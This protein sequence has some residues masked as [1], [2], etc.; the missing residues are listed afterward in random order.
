MLKW[1][2]PLI[3]FL[4]GET[5]TKFV[6]QITSLQ[7]EMRQL[8]QAHTSAHKLLK[9]KEDALEKE[10]RI[11]DEM[12]KKFTVFNFILDTVFL[13]TWQTLKLYF[14]E[15]EGGGLVCI[16]SFIFLFEQQTC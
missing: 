15:M 16:K 4:Q 3:Y 2:C 14:W 9:L 6:N 13:I 12:K 8:A 7:D 1:L 10:K 11:R 5:I